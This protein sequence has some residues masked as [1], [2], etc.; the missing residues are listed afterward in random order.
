MAQ[1]AARVVFILQPAAAQAA[2]AW[3]G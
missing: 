2:V 1:G 3:M